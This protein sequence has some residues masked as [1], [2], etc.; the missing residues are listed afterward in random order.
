MHGI[1]NNLSYFQTSDRITYTKLRLLLFY[2]KKSFK[3]THIHKK[4]I[5]LHKV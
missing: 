3:D 5:P 2:K 1:N 4:T